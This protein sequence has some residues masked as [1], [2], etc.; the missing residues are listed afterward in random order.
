MAK[1]QE[2][3]NYL[4]NMA[5][6]TLLSIRAENP[7]GVTT[8]L[9]PPLIPAGVVISTKA[10]PSRFFMAVFFTEAVIKL[11]K[12]AYSHSPIKPV[13]LTVPIVRGF[14][15]LAIVGGIVIAIV[16]LT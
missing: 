15:Y 10:K 2:K 6:R 1:L 4:N 16:G 5:P 14:G 9:S 12:S 7:N 8:E 3:C 13:G 11:V